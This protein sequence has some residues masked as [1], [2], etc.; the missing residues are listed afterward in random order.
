[1]STKSVL[2][3]TTANGFVVVLEFSG[4][5]ELDKNKSRIE[6]AGLKCECLPI[7]RPQFDHAD[8]FMDMRSPEC[9]AQ[10]D[11]EDWL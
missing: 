8:L 4:R 1:V 6:A 3:F 2:K 5:E 11:L 9:A 7:F 10:F